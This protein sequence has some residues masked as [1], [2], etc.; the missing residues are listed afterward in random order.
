MSQH[1]IL[2]YPQQS[3]PPDYL[4]TVHVLEARNDA[5]RGELKDR[6]KSIADRDEQIIALQD[7]LW[8]AKML[9]WRMRA[10]AA[11]GWGIVALMVFASMTLRLLR[12]F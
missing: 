11:A 10:V 1:R 9:K 5:L 8:W 12:L 2:K 4:R 6:D 7:A 3:A